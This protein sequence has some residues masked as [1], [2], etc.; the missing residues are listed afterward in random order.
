MPNFS[1]PFVVECDAS[2]SGVGAVLMQQNRPIAYFSKAISNKSTA[3][4]AYERELM[5]LVLAIQ[6]WRPYLIGRKFTVRTDQRSLKHFYCSKL[7]PQHKQ[8]WL[9]K[10]MGY[11]F[12][13]EYKTGISNKAADAL[14]R[15]DEEVELQA[16][17]VPQWV[18]WEEI[19]QE[20]M[21]DKQLSKIIAELSAGSKRVVGN[22]PVLTDL[23]VHMEEQGESMVEPDHI[24]QQRQIHRKN[25]WVSQVLVQWKGQSAEQAT[26]IDE[27]DFRGQ[28]PYFS[29][30]DKAASQQVGNDKVEK[31]PRPFKVY[32][33]R[34][35]GQGKGSGISLEAA[36][37]ELVD[38][39]N[40][41]EK[42]T[43]L[44][45]VIT[46]ELVPEFKGGSRGNEVSLG[47]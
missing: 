40:K 39:K 6:H 1:L 27:A 43:W 22:H 2:G 46:E 11:S 45:V 37:A 15:R 12:M 29:L 25:Q 33:R 14:S 26:W 5:A 28:F 32:S 20:V 3:Q 21:K 36:H 30:E 23:P 31:G 9:S 8:Y 41:R 17:S 10:L 16:I 47:Y 42:D 35:K 34:A 13:I 7:A 4:S 19:A 18:D 38:G 24:C 44:E